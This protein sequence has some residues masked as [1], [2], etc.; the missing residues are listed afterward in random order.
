MLIGTEMEIFM[1]MEK[2][3]SFN[4]SSIYTITLNVLFAISGY[5]HKNCFS[6]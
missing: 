4:N 2:Y 1:I 3:S 6:I 5:R